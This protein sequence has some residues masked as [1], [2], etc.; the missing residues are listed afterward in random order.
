MWVAFIIHFYL[1]R[2]KNIINRPLYQLITAIDGKQVSFSFMRPY[3]VL[4]LPP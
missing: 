4:F 3:I 2:K 1:T